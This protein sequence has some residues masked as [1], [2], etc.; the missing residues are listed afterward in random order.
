M[1]GQHKLAIFDMKRILSLLTVFLAAHASGDVS[2][3]ALN[4][5]GTFDRQVQGK[6]SDFVSSLFTRELGLPKD[7]VPI[8]V[9][10]EAIYFE[11]YLYDVKARRSSDK[12]EIVYF[13]NLE[14]HQGRLVV[15]FQDERSEFNAILARM[16]EISDTK[17]FIFSDVPMG[18]LDSACQL[19]DLP[20]NTEAFI[21][22]RTVSK[23]HPSTTRLNHI[24]YHSMWLN[25][26]AYTSRLNMLPESILQV[27]S[28]KY[29]Y[30]TGANAVSWGNELK[31]PKFDVSKSKSSNSLV[32]DE[33]F[34]TKFINPIAVS[35]DD[36]NKA[37]AESNKTP[38]R[39]AKADN[40]ED[41][42]VE[43]DLSKKNELDVS[44]ISSAPVAADDKQEAPMKQDLLSAEAELLALKKQLEAEKA[45]AVVERAKV[46][47][48][49]AQIDAERRLNEEERKKQEKLREKELA[50][51]AKLNVEKA[52][53]ERLAQLARIERI[54]LEKEKE[55][56]EKKKKKR[57]T[58]FSF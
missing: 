54:E 39:V 23:D 14:L 40:T 4:E 11:D 44:Q 57:A 38:N 43:D 2:V 16:G 42:Q 9:Q 53:Q 21:V 50:E 1:V 15:S 46:L 12:N 7:D 36:Q 56:L 22:E 5:N 6:N 24:I 49:R 32:Y 19:I 47:A 51:M 18:Q 52:E 28:D 8:F 33:N 31:L 27:I 25:S 55:A 10:P 26:V 37:V 17:F 48:E 30:C 41:I 45:K 58:S 20:D 3:W 13:S 29:T 34:R 35:A